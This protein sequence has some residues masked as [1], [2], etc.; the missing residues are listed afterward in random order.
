MTLPAPML[1]GDL[2]GHDTP[3]VAEIFNRIGDKWTLLVIRMLAVGPQR[4]TALRSLVPGIS[5]RMLTLTL[6]QLQRDGVVS[7]TIYPEIPPR[8]E[9]ALTELGQ[10]LVPPV[11][12]LAEWAL[13]NEGEIRGNRERY[14][15]LLA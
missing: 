13:A 2:C 3:I 7:R 14:D 4:F 8:V 5:Q 6:R 11:A 12:A 15:E 1:D 10:T 9:Y